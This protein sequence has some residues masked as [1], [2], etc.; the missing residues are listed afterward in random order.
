MG[1][2]KSG[3][4]SN[5]FLYAPGGLNGLKVPFKK[6]K[7]GLILRTGLIHKQYELC[8]YYINIENPEI[9]AKV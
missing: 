6:I 4:R 3:K 9:G 8:I 7:Q 5:I 1:Q 2:V